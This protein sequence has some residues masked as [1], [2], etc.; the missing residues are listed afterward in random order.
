MKAM[1][2]T[3]TRNKKNRN[4]K[5]M[6]LPFFMSSP[7]PYYGFRECRFAHP[8]PTHYNRKKEAG[9]RA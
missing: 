9:D 3:V 7:N 4:I 2:V 6:Y 8:G 1:T 5:R